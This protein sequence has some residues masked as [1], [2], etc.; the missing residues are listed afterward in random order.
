MVENYKILY[1]HIKIFESQRARIGGPDAMFIL[2]LAR[3]QP[4]RSSLNNEKG[5][6]IGRIGQKLRDYLLTGLLVLAPT[7]VTVWV[8]FR[9]LNWMVPVPG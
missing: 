3:I 5:W 9:L 6:T 4:F 1:G 7:A 2:M 8:F